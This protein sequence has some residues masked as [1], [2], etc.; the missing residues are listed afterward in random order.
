MRRRSVLTA[1]LAAPLALSAT[2]RA[3]AA[4]APSGAPAA[5]RTAASEAADVKKKGVSAWNFDGV[6]QDLA[7]SGAGWFYAWSSGRS[8][9]AAPN[10]VEFVPMIWGPGSATDAELDQ[11]KQQGTTLLGFNEPDH[12]GQ[13]AMTVQQA[14][15]LWPRLQS[16]G[17]RL[18]APAVATGADTADGWLDQFLRGAAGR[19]LKVDFLPVHWY[20]AD[21]DAANATSQLRGYLQATYDRHRKPLWLT[22]YALIDFS[23][24]TPRYPTQ[25]QQAAFVQQSTAMLQG[26]PFVERYAWFTLSTSRGDGTG[27]Y[28]GTTATQVGAAYRAAG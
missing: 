27:L 12:P 23:S 26:L 4:Q 16:T 6:A 19:G 25:E 22:E 13:A 11:A 28:D 5:E 21:F 3:A 24:G 8:G 9:I 17:L 1:A 20:G 15:D 7:D 14:L 18:G 2:G 10:G